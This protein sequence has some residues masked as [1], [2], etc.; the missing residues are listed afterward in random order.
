MSQTPSLSHVSG[1]YFG[2]NIVIVSLATAMTVI[3]LNIHNQGHM[4]QR[5]PPCIRRFCFGFLAKVLCVTIQ[6][7]DYHWIQDECEPVTKSTT[8][9]LVYIWYLNF[10]GEDLTH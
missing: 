8:K 4:G 6:P 3:T 9:H 2:I 1:L 7:P 10:Q 5:V